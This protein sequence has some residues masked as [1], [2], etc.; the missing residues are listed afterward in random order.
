MMQTR[1]GNKSKKDKLEIWNKF[2]HAKKDVLVNT[3]LRVDNKKNSNRSVGFF[4]RSR[5]F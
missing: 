4:I 3:A 5:C 2:T 1:S